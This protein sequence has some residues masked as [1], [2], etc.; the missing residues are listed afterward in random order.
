M[1]AWDSGSEA[2]LLA[3]VELGS[4]APIQSWI[5]LLAEKISITCYDMLRHIS[6]YD[7]YL[8]HMRH[9]PFLRQSRKCLGA[10]GAASCNPLE[11]ESIM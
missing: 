10:L 2:L 7:S 1:I 6:F 8:V 5:E 9:L 11:G 4:S 3:V